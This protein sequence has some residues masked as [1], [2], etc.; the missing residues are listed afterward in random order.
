[1]FA[2]RVDPVAYGALSQP[3]CLRSAP[4]CHHGNPI[5]RAA[6]RKCLRI[7]P[8]HVESESYQQ[9]LGVGI[10]DVGDGFGQE[11]IEERSWSYGSH[12]AH[13]VWRP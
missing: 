3:P 5:P 11:P 8:E 2:Y 1:M 12:G 4:A 13:P 6:P 7:A 9:L 10:S